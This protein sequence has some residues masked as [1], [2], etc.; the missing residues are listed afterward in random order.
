MES[1]T[2]NSFKN[3]AYSWINQILAI[4]LGFASRSIFLY[5][6]SVDYLGIQGLFGDILNMLSLADLGFGTAMTFSMYKP[7]AEK[8][9]DKLAGLTNFYKKIY[10]VIAMSITCIGVALI[11]FL[12]YLINLDSDIPN[13]T[14]YYVLSLANTVASYLVI[15][16][17]SIITADQKSYILTKYQ[18]VFS[19]LKTIATS[20]FLLITHNYAVYLAIQVLFTYAQNFYLSYVAR[21]MYPFLDKDVKLPEE[22]T[23][24][25]FKNIGSV[26]L[27]KISSVLINATDNT[28]ISVIVGTAFVGYYANYTML[29]TKLTAFINTLFYS[30]TASLGNLIIKEGKERRFQIFKIMQSVSV[31]LSTFCVTCVLA[32]QQDFIYV[33]LGSQYQLENLVVYA[34]IINFYFSISLLPIWVFREA[35]GLYQKTKYV[36][37]ATAACNILISIAL[38]KMIGLAGIIFATSI[39]RLLTYFWYEPK[40]LFKTYFGHSCKVYFMSVLKSLLVTLLVCLTVISISTMITADGWISLIVKGFAVAGVTGGLE[41]LIY[42]KSEGFILLRAKVKNYTCHASHHLKNK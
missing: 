41:Y 34:L 7:L 5:C 10:R 15:Y 8:D 37:L 6:L 3:I 11:P 35:T 1:R 14:L 25:I 36:M 21:K 42:H 19:I 31:I 9:Y 2:K 26:F 16:R 30:L 39:S 13:L 24:G 17:T 40:L 23:H 27:Y 12:K 18:S 38:G 20:A 4:I 29:V 22:E 32:L 33:W 28:L